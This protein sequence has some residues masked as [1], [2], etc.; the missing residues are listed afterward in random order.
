MQCK[1]PKVQNNDSV[2][3]GGGSWLLHF[4][5]FLGDSDAAGPWNTLSRSQHSYKARMMELPLGSPLGTA[6][7]LYQ[8]IQLNDSSHFRSVSLTSHVNDSFS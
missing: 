6:A 8:S 2:C 7:Y 3:L 5:K 4:T 1:V